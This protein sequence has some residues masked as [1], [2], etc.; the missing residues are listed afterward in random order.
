MSSLF[1]HRR[2]PIGSTAETYRSMVWNNPTLP[3]IGS[4]FS[5]GEAVMTKD[6]L[7]SVAPA[8]RSPADRN[9][10]LRRMMSARGAHSSNMS[11]PSIKKLSLTPQRSAIPP[12]SG[13]ITIEVSR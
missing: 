9:W 10:P 11:A 4:H 5:L 7:Q 1:W 8:A 13:G 6:G 2:A 12:M 3:S